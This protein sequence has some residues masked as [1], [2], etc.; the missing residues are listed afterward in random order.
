[1]YHPV[2]QNLLF[3][4]VLVLIKA[5]HFFQ[6]FTANFK[7]IIIKLQINKLKCMPFKHPSSPKLTLFQPVRGT[8]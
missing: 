8:C 3:I 4:C 7:S 1:M 2:F 5:P 6:R